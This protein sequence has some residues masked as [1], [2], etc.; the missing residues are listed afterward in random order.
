MIELAPSILSA[1]FSR[2]GEDVNQAE[3]EGIRWL[4]ID[5]MDGL[6]VP[7]ISFGFP[8]IKSLRPK[9]RM[10]FD[11]HLMI[12]EPIRYIHEFAKAG[13]DSITVHLEA[14][15][16]VEETL[17]EIRACGCKCGISIN[18]GTPVSEILKY[19]PM[20][21]MVLIMTVE[22]G[23]G[24]QKYIESTTEKIVQLRDWIR[25]QGLDVLIEVDGGI[26]TG[27]I[28]TVLDAGA[29]RIVCGSAVFSG[30]I[31]E[32]VRALQAIIKDYEETNE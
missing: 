24:G 12:R 14:C 4:H 2:L 1:D 6:F 22:P 20:V 10:F 28:R 31:R 27:T 5:V 11:V 16:D 25:E 23:F 21:D 3:Q 17:R 29:T 19:L 26:H 7:S 18:P 13:S 9:S 8:V 15:S 32:N 30:D